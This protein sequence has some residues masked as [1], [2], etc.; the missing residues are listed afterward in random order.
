MVRKN[1]SHWVSSPAMPWHGMGSRTSQHTKKREESMSKPK[2]ELTGFERFQRKLA[3]FTA[4][5]IVVAGL[6]ALVGAIGT[7]VIGYDLSTFK[8]AITE[9]VT[10]VNGKIDDLDSKVNDIHNHIFEEEKGKK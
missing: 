1:L 6:L 3:I 4:I 2:E 5:G 7:V 9:K 10:E 8:T